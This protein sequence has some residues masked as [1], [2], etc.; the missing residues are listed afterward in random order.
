MKPVTF[1]RCVSCTKV[2]SPWDIAEV[3]G[4]TRCGGGRVR[5]TN[6][7]WWEKVVQI[8]RRPRFWR[9]SDV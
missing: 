7:T 3:G 1:Y 4:C 6:L 8:L 9:W 2:V 5:P